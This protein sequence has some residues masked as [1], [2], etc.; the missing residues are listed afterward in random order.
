MMKSQICPFCKK[1][2]TPTRD[3][4]PR[5]YCSLRCRMSSDKQRARENGKI[6]AEL[7]TYIKTKS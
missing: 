7:G 4:L 2:F 3:G 5:T 1:E 6:R